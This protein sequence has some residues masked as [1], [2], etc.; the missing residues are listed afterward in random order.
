MFS[1]FGARPG[2]LPPLPDE[3]AVT[4]KSNRSAA[5][6][7]TI[8]AGGGARD[9]ERARDI[10]DGKVGVATVGSWAVGEISYWTMG[11]GEKMSTS[12]RPSPL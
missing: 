1:P 9:D 7:N 6:R 11:T 10:P 5:P 8:G 12:G 3:E 4:V 2:V